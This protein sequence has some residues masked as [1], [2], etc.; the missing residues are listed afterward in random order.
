[1][2]LLRLRLLK[3]RSIK[4][5]FTFFLNLDGIEFSSSTTQVPPR[6]ADAARSKLRVVQEKTHYRKVYRAQ[7]ESDK[8]DLA[9][10]LL[11]N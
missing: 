7:E 1:M 5:H 6:E 9:G 2:I 10:E 8:T 4:P 3:I 11:V